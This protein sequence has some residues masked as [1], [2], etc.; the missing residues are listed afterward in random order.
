MNR[1]LP[2]GVVWVYATLDIRSLV[3]EEFERIFSMWASGAE[4]VA[5]RDAD[6]IILSGTAVHYHIGYEKSE[7]LGRRIEKSTGIPTMLNATAH[8]NALRAFSANKIILVSPFEAERNEEEKK[9]LEKIGFD[10]INTKGAGLL[11]NNEFSKLPPYTSY[12]LAKEAFYETPGAD[13]ILIECP[14]WEVLANVDA[15]ERDLGKPV[16]SAIAADLWAPLTALNIKGPIRGYG[17]LLEML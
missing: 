9:S 2:E 5:S 11:Y 14:G 1:I 4:Q 7:E 16:V 13:A 10:V 6:F 15:L 3:P 17:K 8:I 12:R